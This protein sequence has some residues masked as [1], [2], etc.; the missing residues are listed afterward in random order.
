MEDEVVIACRKNYRLFLFV[1][2]ELA[3]QHF[4]WLKLSLNGRM[5]SG[6]GVL[7]V[8]DRRYQVDLNYSPFFPI[9]FD[10]ILIKGISYHPKIHVYGDL[11]LCLYHPVQDMPLFRTIPLVEMIPWIS[12]WCVHYQEWQKY[13]V[14]LGKEISH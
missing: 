14:W 11:S 9:R 13:G 3:R 8:G 2:M 12:E 1:Q 5:I 4:S 10:R 6:S 7:E